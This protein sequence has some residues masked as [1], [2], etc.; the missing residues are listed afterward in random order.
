MRRGYQVYK[1]VCAACHSMQYLP[2]RELVNVI[3]TEDEAK[4]EAEDVCITN[5]K[6]IWLY[7][8]NVFCIILSL[9]G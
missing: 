6:S 3:F 2:Y 4:K 8:S 5:T 9:Q 1:E 7:F